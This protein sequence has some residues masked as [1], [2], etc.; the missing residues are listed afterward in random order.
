MPHLT[1]EHSDSSLDESVHFEH[2]S[3]ARGPLADFARTPLY[4]PPVASPVSRPCRPLPNGTCNCG[5]GPSAVHTPTF[6]QLAAVNGSVN[7]VAYCSNPFTGAEP[8]Y[9]SI[10]PIR[11]RVVIRTPSEYL[12]E[13]PSTH[14]DPPSSSDYSD[15]DEQQY[16]ETTRRPT[17]VDQ[18]QAEVNRMLHARRTGQPAGARL[19][20]LPILHRRIGSP[21]G[22]EDGEFEPHYPETTRRPTPLDQAQAE[23]NRML[24]AQGTA[25]VRRPSPARLPSISAA[26]ETVAAMSVQ[27]LRVSPGFHS[28]DDAEGNVGDGGSGSNGNSYR[29]NGNNV[30]Q[31]HRA[32]IPYIG[33]LGA[34]LP[35]P[36]LL[37]EWEDEELE[38]ALPSPTAST[39]SSDILND[40]LYVRHSSA[41]A[42]SEISH[43]SEFYPAERSDSDQ[44][45]MPLPE[46]GEPFPPFPFASPRVVP[47]VLQPPHPA[48]TS[49]A[50]DGSSTDA[51]LPMPMWRQALAFYDVDVE[52]ADA[53]SGDAIVHNF[54]AAARA[55]DV[56]RRRLVSVIVT[57]RSALTARRGGSDNLRW[58]DCT[59]CLNCRQLSNAGQRSRDGGDVW[60]MV[61][62]IN[63]LYEHDRYHW[64]M[65]PVLE[66]GDADNFFERQAPRRYNLMDRVYHWNLLFLFEDPFA[67]RFEDSSTED[68]SPEDDSP[69]D[70]DSEDEAPVSPRTIPTGDPLE[71]WDRDGAASHGSGSY[72]PASISPVPPETHSDEGW[73]HNFSWSQ[74]SGSARRGSDS[75]SPTDD[76]LCPLSPTTSVRSGSLGETW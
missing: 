15:D 29:P 9:S 48:A 53:L 31:V 49:S 27:P 64:P 63:V 22:E 25:A 59:W 43:Y 42:W 44:P 11:A 34:I 28:S 69:E 56:E 58:S 2:L 71:G 73:N 61:T 6:A 35:F 47:P 39:R 52:S 4:P 74:A 12:G 18:A 33:P 57:T 24:R 8:D 3:T 14:Q 40:P 51:L 72:S 66:Y 65:L 41:S 68:D 36:P 70:E 7:T 32:I 76:E 10:R 1:A 67:P 21:S 13:G 19:A 75:Y 17:P 62:A 23:V 20:V 38:E 54:L 37:R 16:P 5:L 30:Y 60:C 46:L 26:P 45:A 50:A 55:T